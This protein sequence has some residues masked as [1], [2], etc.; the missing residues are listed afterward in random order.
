MHEW[1]QESIIEEERIFTPYGDS[2]ESSVEKIVLILSKKM[3]G[4]KYVDK[5]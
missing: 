5:E 4:K 1:Y 2:R 3:V